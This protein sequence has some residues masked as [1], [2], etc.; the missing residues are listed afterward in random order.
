MNRKPSVHASFQLLALV[1]RTPQT[2]VRL[3]IPDTDN[4]CQSTIYDGLINAVFHL[5]G[6]IGLFGQ[7]AKELNLNLSLNTLEISN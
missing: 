6:H 4:S 3:H 7:Y 2:G 1:G 5:C